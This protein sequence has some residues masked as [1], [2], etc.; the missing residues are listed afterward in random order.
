MPFFTV[1]IP[2]YNK[3]K[4]IASTLNS[5]MAQMFTDF[6]VLIIDDHSTDSSLQIA[7]KYVSDSISVVQHQANQ[8]LS[9]AR[10][11][12]I[13]KA[14]SKYVAFLDSDDLWNPDFLEQMHTLINR[15]PEA[16][17]FGSAYEEIYDGISLE[18]DKNVQSKQGKMTLISDF[19]LANAH[20]PI[21]C[22]SSVVIKREVFDE[23][24]FFDER[25]TL[26]EDVDFNIRA[27]QKYSVAYLNQVCA[28]YIIFSENQITTSSISSKMVTDF[29]KYELAAATNSSLKLYLDVNRYFLAMRYKLYGDSAKSK[30]LV[31]EINLQN[32][33]QR[34]IL[35]LKS[36]IWIVNLVR[37][38][39]FKLLQ[40]GIRLTTFRAS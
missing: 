10:N 36:P 32:L 23:I 35:L 25:I 15:F 4:Y 33:T 9:A 20:Q 37:K 1:V 3:E 26:G 5:V 34:Q 40:K 16:G 13:K 6:E 19:F 21:F 18:V 39:K 38:I 7:R 12:G 22:Y 28:G 24:G 8:G 2:L 14:R 11:T 27:G 30:A 29:N 31:S 17:I